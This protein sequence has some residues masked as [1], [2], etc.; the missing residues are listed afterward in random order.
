MR[1]TLPNV[2]PFAKLPNGFGSH[3]YVYSPILLDSQYL[4]H[5]IYPRDLQH[6]GCAPES[7]NYYT[8]QATWVADGEW[9]CRPEAAT[10]VLAAPAADCT[11]TTYWR[12]SAVMEAMD[13]AEGTAVPGSRTLRLLAGTWLT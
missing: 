13:N 9:R 6:A 3:R 8:Y 1:I 5:F 7:C 4:F 12:V 10:A 2:W 11:Y